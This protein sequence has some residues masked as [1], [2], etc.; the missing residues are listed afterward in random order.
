MKTKIVLGVDLGTEC[1]LALLGTDGKLLWKRTLFCDRQSQAEN[2]FN[3]LRQ[4]LLPDWHVA[5]E[6]AF[7]PFPNSRYV[8]ERMAGALLSACQLV[9]CNN[10]P[11]NV[12][13]LKKFATGDGHAKKDAMMAAAKRRW[14]G[15][16]W[17]SHEA[18]AAWAAAMC[19]EKVLDNPATKESKL[20]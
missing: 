9:G 4:M 14:S 13:A 20:T 5:W 12:S 6:E 10:T 3:T 7:G 15:E 8:H 16:E 1:G 18:D 19:R 17:N 2:L 11:L